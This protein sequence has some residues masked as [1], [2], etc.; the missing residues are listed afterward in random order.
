MKLIRCHVEN[1]GKL[2]DFDYSWTEGVNCICRENGWGKSTL[3]AFIKCMFYGLTGDNRKSAADSERKKYAPWQGGIFGGKILFESGGKEYEV[4]RTWGKKASE[5][6]C[7]IIDADTRLGTK[8]YDVA[9]SG[10]TDSLGR[11]LFGIDED[12]FA[13]SAYIAQG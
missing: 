3:M 9:T 6:T 4:I 1:F 2:H 13:R 8:D 11:Q 7:L 5:D 10:N 12:S